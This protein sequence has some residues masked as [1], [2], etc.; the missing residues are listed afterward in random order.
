MGAQATA[1]LGG[2]QKK[3]KNCNPVKKRGDD[4]HTPDMMYTRGCGVRKT[5]GSRGIVTQVD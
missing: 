4:C 1:L 5:A 2:S 3:G